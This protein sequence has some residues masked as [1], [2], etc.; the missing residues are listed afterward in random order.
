MAENKDSEYWP[1]YTA[2]FS[3]H[4][5]Q[6]PVDQFVYLGSS[7]NTDGRSTQEIH[8]R[9]GMVSGVM[10]RLSNVWQQSRLSLATKLRVYNSLVLSVLLYG[11]ETWTI[12]KSDERKL[13]AFHMSCQ[14]RIFGIRWFHCVTNAEVTSQMEQE[15]LTSHICRWRAAVFGHVRRLPE[16]APGRMDMRLAVDM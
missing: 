12:L 15:D 16:E 10:G 3:I 5:G 1:R 4:A 8:H 14:R 7:I 11:C 9:I 2:I 13:E 6:W